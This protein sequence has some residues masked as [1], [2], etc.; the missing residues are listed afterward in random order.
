[1]SRPP[2]PPPI[3]AGIKP[4]FEAFADA[5]ARA[6]ERLQSLPDLRKLLAGSHTFESERG[7]AMHVAYRQRTLARRRK[8]RR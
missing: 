8:A 5:L 1:M 3:L 6:I 7:S 2:F 4:S